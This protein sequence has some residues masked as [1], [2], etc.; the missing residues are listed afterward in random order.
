[1]VEKRISITLN[2]IKSAVFDLQRAFIALRA[3]I[4]G[5]VKDG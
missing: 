1:M 2:R 3:I 5:E 4:V